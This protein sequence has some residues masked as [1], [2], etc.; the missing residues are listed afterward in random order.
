RGTPEVTFSAVL[1]KL[2]TLT[3]D[4]KQT[5]ANAREVTQKL[6]DASGEIPAI[7]HLAHKAME[8]LATTGENA[9]QTVLDIK[10]RIPGVMEKLHAALDTGKAT[11][12]TV[13]EFFGGGTTN[14]KETLAHLNGITGK[15]DTELPQITQK[16]KDTVDSGHNLLETGRARMDEAKVFVA[17]V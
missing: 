5:F 10:Q 14:F 4:L 12:A 3:P 1:A 6:K 2:D 9:S 15:L 16:V 7:A 13:G 17:N 11:L 8:A